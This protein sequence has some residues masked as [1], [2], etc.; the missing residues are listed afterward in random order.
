MSVLK[1]EFPS[2]MENILLVESFIDKAKDTFH[3]SDD[4]YGNIMVSI[5]ESVNNAMIHGNHNEP[6][7]MV[8]LEMYCEN[9]TL[10]CTIIDQGI[11]FDY[12]NLP[13]PTAPE[14]I[15]KPGGRGI[16]LIRN[17]ADKVQFL[18]GGKKI[19]LSF[20]L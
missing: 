7:K 11:G 16:F 9:K 6:S 18:D 10:T 5:T 2:V 4:V 1:I 8:V 3:I 13:D 14:N 17:L 19:E 15:N 12:S 20:A